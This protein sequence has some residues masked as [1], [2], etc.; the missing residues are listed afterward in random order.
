MTGRWM[1][2]ATAA[3][4]ALALQVAGP[5]A[6]GAEQDR[7]QAV[8]GP[9]HGLAMHGRPKYGP[10]FSHFDYVVPD[11]PKGGT[12][13]LADIGSFDT[14][15]PF[16]IKGQ[17]AAGIGGTLDTLL[18]RAEDEPFT[19]YG[20]LAE[21]VETPPDRSWVAFTLR[22]EARWHDGRPVTPEDVIFTFE[23]LRDKGQPIYRFYYAGVAKVEKS[24]ERSVKFTFVP[25]EN[26]ELPLILGE[27]SIL[28]KHYWEGRDFTKTTLEPPLGSGPFEVESVDPGRSIVYRRVADYWGRDLPVNRGRFNFDRIRYDYYRDA[29]VAIEALKAGDYDFRAENS[30]KDW[31]TAYDVAALREGRLV[32]L[33]VKHRRTAGMQGFVYNSRRP[34][35]RD[36]RVREALA[37]AFDFEWSNRNL[38]YGQY[39][40]TRSYFDNSE[41][42]ATGLPG[43]EELPL[44]EPYRGRIPEQV[45]TSEYNPP[46]TDG[47]GRIRDNLRQADRLL[48]EAGWEIVGGKRVQATNSDKPMEFEILLVSP[49]FERVALPFVKNLERL[50]V[51]AHVR[52]VDSAQYVRRV[53][54]FDFDMIVGTFGQS[55]SPGNEQRAYWGSAAARQPGSRNAMGIE[56]PVVDEL[57][58][59][60]IAA[61]DRDGLVVRT[62]ALDRVLQWGHWLIPHWHLDYDR[63]VFWD[64]FGRPETTPLTGYQFDTWWYDTQGKGAPDHRSGTTKGP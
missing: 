59:A 55:Q 7:E 29:T 12:V 38:F 25:G 53:D 16:I 40:R 13:R 43:P 27:L 6:A 1:R 46:A 33:E 57:V 23:T 47:Q 41:L 19:M 39:T 2:A 50:G 22:K 32:K 30:S 24:G 48:K 56:D 45:L 64:M 44:L 4:V 18:A 5:M 8:P 61:P 26:R 15:N 10:D 58:E 20:L 51:I 35:F 60:V 52:T 36:A 3:W 11:A 31:A 62:R 49:L 54:D 14:L 34:L 9:V 63:L 17:A 21:S 37:Y 28:P 42:A